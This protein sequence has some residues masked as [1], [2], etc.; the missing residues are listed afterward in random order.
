MTSQQPDG[1]E[2]RLAYDLLGEGEPLLL[3]HG[4]LGD[5]AMWA[6]QLPALAGHFRVIAPDLRGFGDSPSPTGPVS[7]HDDL[8]ALLES[9]GVPRVHVVGLSLG[10]RVALDL[11]LSYPGLVRSLT[12][13]GAGLAGHEWTAESQRQMEIADELLD[14]GDLAGGIDR[15]MDLW[16]AGPRRSLDQVD[17][18]V[19][20][21]VRAMM[22]RNYQRQQSEEWDVLWIENQ[23]ER[24]GEINVPALIVVGGED[25]PDMHRI[26]DTLAAGIPNAR[27]AEVA[28]AAH[29][30]HMER[31]EEVNALILQFLAP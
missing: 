15:E 28:G 18:D 25:I 10:G 20:R 11:T 22:M 13:I 30:P 4:G 21:D 17:D 19:V 31:P 29:H 14:A 16:I 3:I 7:Y 23:A 6:A 1:I 2:E 12:L 9:L 26:A 8:R 5:R 24:L 27:R